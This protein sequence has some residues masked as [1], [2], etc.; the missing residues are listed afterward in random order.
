MRESWSV[1]NNKLQLMESLR[2]ELLNVCTV[3]GQ[4]ALD[5]AVSMFTNRL[6]LLEVKCHKMIERMTSSSMMTSDSEFDDHMNTD[7]NHTL[8]SLN[9][10]V[11]LRF[12]I[13]HSISKD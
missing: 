3:D 10:L 8:D 7:D 4:V 12:L 6:E 9:L 5:S 2:D 11:Y 13:Y 1:H